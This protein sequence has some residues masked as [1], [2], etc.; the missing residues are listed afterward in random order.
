MVP[1]RP[2]VDVWLVSPAAVPTPPTAALDPVELARAAALGGGTGARFAIGRALLRAALGPRLGCAPAEVALTASCPDCPRPHGRVLVGGR[3]AAPHVSV[4]RAGPLVAV[5]VTDDGPVGID[6]E[7]VA[8][9]VPAIADIVLSPAERDGYDAL[10]PESRAAALARAW[11]RTEAALKAVGTGLRVEP[12]RVEVGGDV[13]WLPAER[14][15]DAARVVLVDLRLDEATSGAVALLVGPD[16]P[17]V[18][19]I[20]MHDGAALLAGRQPPSG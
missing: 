7:S 2:V 13:A 4:T 16:G 9:V 8:A 17:T 20:R 5:A 12:R 3:G 14:G 6:I 1:A 19:S 15:R 11:V 10:P 18:P